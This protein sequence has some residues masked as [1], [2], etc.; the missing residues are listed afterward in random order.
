ML[1]PSLR[2]ISAA[3]E[4]TN[5]CVADAAF[6]ADLEFVEE[7]SDATVTF[8]DTGEGKAG[9]TRAKKLCAI[10]AGI[11]KKQTFALAQTGY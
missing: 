1:A 2:A 9:E 10:R 5:G 4:K 6:T 8:K 7:H 3:R 11:L